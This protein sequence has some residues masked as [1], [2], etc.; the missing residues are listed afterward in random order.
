MTPLTSR[1]VARNDLYWRV[2]S[3][4]RQWYVMVCQPALC[5]A[6]L[7][8]SIRLKPKDAMLI[9]P[10]AYF[11]IGQEGKFVRRVIVGWLVE[12][13]M[14][15]LN[16][17]LTWI[18]RVWGICSFLLIAA[19][20]FGGTESMRPTVNEAIG[21]L[22]FPVGVLVGFAIAWWREGTGGLV[23]VSSFAFFYVWLFVRDGR[24]PI[25]PYFLLFAAPGF[26]HFGNALWARVQSKRGGQ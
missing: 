7:L 15:K 6:R 10:A 17:V 25:G 9:A 26:I 2:I 12:E 4:T 21:L 22:L 19:F 18:A 1:E 24:L 5:E 8:R 16:R 13:E 23:A 3:K 14:M 20:M 11:N